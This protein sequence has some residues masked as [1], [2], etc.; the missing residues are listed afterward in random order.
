MS[1]KKLIQQYVTTG[2]KIPKEQFTKLGKSFKRSYLRSRING[3]H[4]EDNPLDEY[5]LDNIKLAPEESVKVLL[6]KIPKYGLGTLYYLKTNGGLNI[7]MP[8]TKFD[9]V[10][11]FHNIDEFIKSNMDT[12]TINDILV[13]EF[14]EWGWNAEEYQYAPYNDENSEYIKKYIELNTGGDIDNDDVSEE[15]K[16]YYDM[17][18]DSD[19][20]FNMI[21]DS[22]Y[23]AY[24]D[25]LYKNVRNGLISTFE[26]WGEVTVNFDREYFL[27]KTD[28]YKIVDITK[29][30]PHELDEHIYNQTTRDGSFTYMDVIYELVQNGKLDKLDANI[31][32][33][34]YYD[35]EN[36]NEILKNRLEE[37]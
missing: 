5:E 12:D 31:D 8:E 16:E 34:I 24:Q 28:F 19:E 15:L 33:D 4:H 9:L 26:E 20:I 32:T 25:E 11:D 2:A 21:N 23:Q 29:Y 30:Y 3:Y 22:A 6:D 14:T 13:G 1:N 17:Y 36:F 10:I 18:D 35:D 37:L 7:D 27:I